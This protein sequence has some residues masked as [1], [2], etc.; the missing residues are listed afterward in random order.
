MTLPCIAF[1]GL[2]SS[3]YTRWISHLYL[4]WLTHDLCFYY[5]NYHSFQDF[6]QSWSLWKYFTSYFHGKLVMKCR[7]DPNRNYII[8]NHPHGLYAINIIANI[9]ANQ[10]FKTAFSFIKLRV[11]TLP[12]NFYIPLW[13]EFCLGLGSISCDRN[14]VYSILNGPKNGS[15]VMLTVGGAKEFT[16][17]RNGMSR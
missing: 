10:S 14:T 15:A 13:R 4:V 17:M 16:L 11:A 3:I 12:I 9:L 6:V 5:T 8:A 2:L 7:L 1:L